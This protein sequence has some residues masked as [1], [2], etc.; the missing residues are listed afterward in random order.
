MAE[1]LGEGVLGQCDSHC[2]I[3]HTFGRLRVLHV[4]SPLLKRILWY[5]RFAS[6]I[7]AVNKNNHWIFIIYLWL[8]NFVLRLSV[9]LRS[10]PTRVSTRFQIGSSTDR[11]TS[12][13]V[14]TVRSCPMVWTTSSVRIWSE[15]RKSA[16]TEAFVTSG[17]EYT[18]GNK[19]GADVC[20]IAACQILR[21]PV[22]SPTNRTLKVKNWNC[23]VSL[24]IQLLDFK[25]HQTTGLMS[26]RFHNI[27]FLNLSLCEPGMRLKMKSVVRIIWYIFPWNTNPYFIWKWTRDDRQIHSGL[28]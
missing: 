27:R 7:F 14:N 13:T 19:I 2:P 5:F 6:C 22:V 8:V 25:L 3:W 18:N 4:F 24:I 20:V 11:R 10:C 26:V 12:R 15:W 16:R 23:Y 1:R 17:G 9:L 21:F 28:L